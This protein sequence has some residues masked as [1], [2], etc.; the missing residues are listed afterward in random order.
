MIPS[1]GSIVHYRLSES[2]VASI[3]A[4]RGPDADG[5]RRGNPVAEGDVFPLVITRVWAG[6]EDVREDTAVNGQVLLDGNDTLWV[7][8]R[9]QIGTT[10]LVNGT[11]S[12]PQEA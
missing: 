6:L 8:S 10:R 7:T 3:V 4:Q 11:W 12:D 1:I 5:A 9:H 2:D